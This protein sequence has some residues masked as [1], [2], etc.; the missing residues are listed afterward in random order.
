MIDALRRRADLLAASREFFAARG[1][2]EVET[3]VL[4]REGAVDAHIDPIAVS[5]RAIG[6]SPTHGSDDFSLMTSPE[7]CMKRLLVGST[8]AIYQI[9]RAF[10]SGERG[11]LHSPEFTL[12]EWYRP[13]FGVDQLMSEV[14]AY[15]GFVAERLRSPRTLEATTRQTYSELFLQ[16]TGLDPL[17]ADVTALTRLAETRGI[18]VSSSFTEQPRDAW[19]DLIL[20]ELVQPELRRQGATFVTEYPVSQAALARQSPRDPRVAERFELFIDGIEVANGY[21][22]LTDPVEQRR[23]FIAANEERERQGKDALSL[24]E[25]F[26]RALEQG[27]PEASGVAL[28]L[29]RLLMLLSGANHIDDVLPFPIERT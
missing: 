15:V 18:D 10:R 21:R 14:G 17:T 13:D 20:S 23:R 2:L 25:N 9:T 28:G 12:L 4:C 3:P 1:V 16:I 6:A 27:M 8:G 22:E 7:L 11:R 19:L 24:P 26:L 29:D 5:G